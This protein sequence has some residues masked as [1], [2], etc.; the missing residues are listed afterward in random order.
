MGA[1][2]GGYAAVHVQQTAVL[3]G[4]KAF[5]CKEHFGREMIVIA[6]VGQLDMIAHFDEENVSCAVLRYI[7]TMLNTKKSVSALL[8]MPF[9]QHSK[10]MNMKLSG[11][12]HFIPPMPSPT[13]TYIL[14]NT[15]VPVT[16]SSVPSLRL[17]S[18]TL[19]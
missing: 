2:E 9:K 7:Q 19:S 4:R 13:T 6:L 17:L 14:L 16:Y 1:V 18:A 8:H 12:I 3:A 10:A 15:F 11:V 5:N